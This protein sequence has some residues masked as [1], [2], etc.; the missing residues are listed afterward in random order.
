MQHLTA[1]TSPRSILD[2]VEHFCRHGERNPNH[3]VVA[4][5]FDHEFTVDQLRPALPPFSDV[6]RSRRPH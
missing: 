1:S 4:A 6:T 5:E 3:F 2:A